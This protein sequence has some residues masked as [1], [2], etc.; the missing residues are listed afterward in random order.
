M[1]SGSVEESRVSDYLN[2][3]GAGKILT[4]AEP[5]SFDYVPDKLVGRDE[6]LQ[7]MASM[8]HQISDHS[9]SC[10]VALTGNVGSGKTALSHVFSRDLVRHLG[11]Q[12][13]VKVVHIN[14][15]NHPSKAQVLHRIVTSLDS[16]HPERGFGSGEIL[17]SVRRQLASASTHLLL[18]LDEVDHLLRADKGD[19]LYQLLR[20]DEG[21]EQRGN[22]SLVIISQEQVLD[23]LES[24]ILSRFGRSN[25]I[26]LEPYN[27][28]ELTA[29]ATQRAALSCH[30][31][32]VAEGVL[33]TIGQRASETGDARLAIE[34]L[35]DSIRKA[36]MAGRPEV[37]AD[38]VRFVAREVGRT[39]EPNIIDH[40]NEHSQMIL[41]ALCRRLRREDEVTTG[42]AEKLYH[43]IC[44]E[45]EENPRSHTTFWK[46][47]K[48]LEGLE[49]IESR[50]A[51][52]TS[53]RGRTQH[54]SM[55]TALPGAL[56]KR[57]ESSLARRNRR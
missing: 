45:Y 53:G 29:I 6:Q 50:T 13:P 3:I 42:D 27:S 56:E 52:R 20:I 46:N 43:V 41:L 35:A 25:H 47:L 1:A 5:L 48:K 19:L 32:S 4:N 11:S 33:R 2:R 28:D 54:L 44:E 12:R 10:Q 39:V 55:P 34:L 30:D 40:L 18:I 51:S 21:R 49:L 9:A 8:F 7:K 38:D 31:G 22:I 14:C 17:E 15:R 24:A 37:L 36:E 23:Q 16:R 57:I 26:R